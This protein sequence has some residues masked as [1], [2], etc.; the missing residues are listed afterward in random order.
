[1]TTPN[2]NIKVAVDAAIFTI[3]N[4]SLQ[5]LLIQMKKNP[6]TESWAIPGGMIQNDETTLDSALRILTTQ[7]GLRGVFLEQLKTF[8]DQTRDPAG[9]VIS[10]AH[11]A[12]V[13]DHDIQLKTTEKYADV[14][15]WNV[16]KLPKLAYDHDLIVKEALARLKSKIQYT[17]IVWSLLPVEFT[18][19]QLQHVYEIILG[20]AMDKRNF[21]KRISDLKLIRPVGK[22]ST[23]AA[24][25]P[26]ELFSFR[27]RKLDY[28]EIV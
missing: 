17:N 15:W 7:T 23:G 19:T 24:H 14:R 13:P 10:V 22:K 2:Q 11:W 18:L 21:R 12:L 27:Q 16:N 5:I 20:N 26:A 25:R 9:R 4:D 8:D 28:V 6:F 1:M 3:K